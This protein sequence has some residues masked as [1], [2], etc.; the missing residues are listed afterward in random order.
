VSEEDVQLVAEKASVS[1]AEARK[2]LEE[3]DGEPAE[4]IIRL[5]SR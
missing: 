1:E 2:A 5:M 4:A 3:A